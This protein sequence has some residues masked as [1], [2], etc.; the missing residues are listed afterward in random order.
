MRFQNK[1]TG[2]WLRGRQGCCG[3]CYRNFS[4]QS[5]FDAH[6]V[7]THD[8]RRCA[9]PE[10]VGLVLDGYIWRNPSP[11]TDYWKESR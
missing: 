1:Y 11:K 10:T 8:S 4:S 9:D 3:A 2:E 7:G 5:A 6:R